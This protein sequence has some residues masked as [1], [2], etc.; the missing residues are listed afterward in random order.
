MIDVVVPEPTGGA[1]TDHEEAAR[2]LKAALLRRLAEVQPEKPRRLLDRRYKRYREFGRYANPLAATVA[3]K[4]DTLKGALH[5]GF[6]DVI[7]RRP[8]RRPSEEPPAGVETGDEAEI[9]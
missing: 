4:V 1:H 6:L 9:P 7:A 2:L 8:V 3:R 5:R